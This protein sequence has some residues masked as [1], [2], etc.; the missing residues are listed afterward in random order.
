MYIHSL[1]GLISV[2]TISPMREV[3][4]VAVMLQQAH[5]GLNRGVKTIVMHA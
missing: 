3:P 4:E 1:N 5:R 2:G